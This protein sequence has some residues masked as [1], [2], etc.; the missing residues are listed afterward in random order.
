MGGT[1]SS[2]SRRRRRRLSNRGCRI[3]R[4]E[5]RAIRR[6]PWAGE[7]QQDFS[8]FVDLVYRS[9]ACGKVDTGL[10]TQLGL[11]M[12]DRLNEEE[13][14]PGP[15]AGHVASVLAPGPEP[16]CL[17]ACAASAQRLARRSRSF[18]AAAPM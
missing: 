7:G 14:E 9:N 2:H 10:F 17:T 8:R 3:T 16:S 12:L 15:A 11:G 4:A 18:A 6:L 5:N 1:R 13:Q